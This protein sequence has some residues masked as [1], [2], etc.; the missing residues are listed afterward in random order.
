MLGQLKAQAF[1][2][3]TL[4][5]CVRMEDFSEHNN[6]P[7]FGQ[8]HRIFKQVNL[9][10]YF[11]TGLIHSNNLLRIKYR[12]ADI[13]N[14]SIYESCHIRKLMDSCNTESVRRG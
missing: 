1:S 13:A 6:A 11:E 3:Y 12:E 9:Q 5:N 8:I 14:Y 10:Y 7:Q 2:S 4:L